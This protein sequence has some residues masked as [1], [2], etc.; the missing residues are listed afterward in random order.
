M[1]KLISIKHYSQVTGITTQASH[2]R[3]SRGTLKYVEVSGH[4]L[5]PINKV[6][7]NVPFLNSGKS[8][9]SVEEA[10]KHLKKSSSMI[11]LMVR[12]REI[13]F[14]KLGG[15]TFIPVDQFEGKL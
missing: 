6:P 5:V 11:Q 15:L 13:N 12:A 8:Y 9:W 3:I 10:A 4:K 7:K 2:L 1:A 14:T